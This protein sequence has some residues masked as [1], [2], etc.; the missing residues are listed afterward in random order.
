MVGPRLPPQRQ[1]IIVATSEETLSG[2][3]LGE[4]VRGLREALEDP[5]KRG[6]PML[7]Q[8]PD[9]A[10][11]PKHADCRDHRAGREAMVRLASCDA[12]R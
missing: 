11:V 12:L 8:E 4:T 2:G 7:S 5:D 9:P 6:Q 10:L 1:E 3:G